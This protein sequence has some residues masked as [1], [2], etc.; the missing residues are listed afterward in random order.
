MNEYK[1]FVIRNAAAKSYLE[2]LSLERDISTSK[3][4]KNEKDFLV[5]L[6]DFQVLYL[7]FSAT[8]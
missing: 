4:P 5:D 7:E 6:V 8:T 3:L 1:T 2:L